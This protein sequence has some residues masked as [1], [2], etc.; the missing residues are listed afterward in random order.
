MAILS[1]A[2]LLPAYISGG[3]ALFIAAGTTVW[4]VFRDIRQSRKV[5]R[6]RIDELLRQKI[7][8]YFVK[9]E[10]L[11]RVYNK[12]LSKLGALETDSL[13]I[14]DELLAIEAVITMLEMLYLPSFMKQEHS[15][16]RIDYRLLMAF[17]EHERKVSDLSGALGKEATPN[18]DGL[19]AGWQS[20]RDKYL[21]EADESRKFLSNLDISK[22]REQYEHAKATSLG[23]RGT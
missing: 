23:K 17:K 5:E 16:S 22:L 21:A 14:H 11:L 10:D 12:W 15:T 18:I 13:T 9:S 3:V 1:S 4:Q 6:D 19:R 20:L 8:E 2:A 7:E